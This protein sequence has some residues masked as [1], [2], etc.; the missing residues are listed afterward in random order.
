MQVSPQELK[1]KLEAKEELLLLDVRT[2]E[3]FVD[4]HIHGAINLP[5]NELLRRLDTIPKDKDIVAICAHGVRSRT[6][7]QWLAGSG[8]SAKTLSGG[9]AAWNS[10]Y[11]IALIPYTA[12]R[13][14]KLFQL[15]RL[16]KGCLEYMLVSGNEVAIID[17]THHIQEFVNIAGSMLTTSLGRGCSPAKLVQSCFLMN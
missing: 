6:A 8:Y 11:D 16:G 7:T 14:F 13:D 1:H 3:E 10:V 17:P 12:T 4:W 5:M 2:P 9:M 15:K